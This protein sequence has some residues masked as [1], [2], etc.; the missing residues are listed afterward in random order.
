M[1]NPR[2]D[3]MA[4]RIDLTREMDVAYWCRIF[5]VTVDELRNAVR[6]AGH[7]VEDVERYLRQQARSA[8]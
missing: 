3:P 2:V 4:S 6:Q 8:G 5:D 1:D 7:R